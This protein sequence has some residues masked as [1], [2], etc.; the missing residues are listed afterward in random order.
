MMKLQ[1]GNMQKCKVVESFQ[2]KF[3]PSKSGSAGSLNSFQFYKGDIYY[4]FVENNVFFIKSL[5]SGH[6]PDW[7]KG[8]PF[9]E[10][11]FRKYFISIREENLKKLL[12]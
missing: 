10:K 3:D 11:T 8:V 2:A 5:E 6:Y 1:V 12:N 9:H 7:F 4:F